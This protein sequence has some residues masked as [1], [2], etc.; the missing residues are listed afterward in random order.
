MFETA[1]GHGSYNYYSYTY[2][3]Y[4]NHGYYYHYS[5]EHCY[6]N[7]NNWIT[8]CSYH[9]INRNNEIPDFFYTSSGA[10]QTIDP[11]QTMSYEWCCPVDAFLYVFEGSSWNDITNS[12]TGYW[13]DSLNTHDRNNNAG[14]MS[15]YETS[16]LSYAGQEV[17]KRFKLYLRNYYN[18]G[19]AAEYYFSMTF[20]DQC[21]DNNLNGG[22]TDVILLSD[23]YFTAEADRS[24][25]S[26]SKTIA[27][28]KGD[29]GAGCNNCDSRCPL[30]RSD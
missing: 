10:A 30:T 22:N 4:D 12:Y 7:S 18:H 11:P 17:T 14:T 1:G 20:R 27:H 24:T 23:M 29:E 15:I 16:A 5:G 13:I 8:A 19:Y 3:H 25:A 9:L 21:L 6:N 2:N 26:Q 28:L